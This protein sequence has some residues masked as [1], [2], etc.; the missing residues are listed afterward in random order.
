MVCFVIA[1]ILAII[2]V[3]GAQKLFME[4]LDIYFMFYSFKSKFVAI[5]IVTCLIF[6]GLLKLTGQIE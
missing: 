4:I 3:N 6:Y 1:L 5:G 2:I